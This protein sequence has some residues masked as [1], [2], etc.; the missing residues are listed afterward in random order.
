[1]ASKV[2]LVDDGKSPAVTVGEKVPVAG[3]NGYVRTVDCKECN[4]SGED[5]DGDM[6]PGCLCGACAQERFFCGA[7]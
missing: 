7:C 5:E 2:K 6:C 1:M 4:G 3:K